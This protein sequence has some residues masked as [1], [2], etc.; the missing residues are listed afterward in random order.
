MASA[1]SVT[2]SLQYYTNDDTINKYFNPIIAANLNSTQTVSTSEFKETFDYRHAIQ[3]YDVSYIACRN[4]EIEA[5]FIRDPAFNLVFINS[6]VA[7]FKVNG[8]L[9]QNG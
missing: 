8:N 4:P 5:K 9:K 2:D 6:E 7:I 1:Y 3:Y